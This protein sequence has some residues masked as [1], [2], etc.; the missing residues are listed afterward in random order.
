V[1]L[2]ACPQCFGIGTLDVDEASA[3]V[4]RCRSC[5]ARWRVTVGNALIP[6]GASVEGWTLAQAYNSRTQ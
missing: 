1:F 4:I 2:W 6:E 5:H 3:S